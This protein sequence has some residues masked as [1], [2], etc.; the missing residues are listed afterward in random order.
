MTNEPAEPFR[1]RWLSPGDVNGF[2][3]LTID[4]L[5]LLAGMSAILVG[6]FHLPSGLVIGRM[7][8]GSALG[9]L[10]GDLAYTALAIRLA[11]CERRGDVCAMPLGI[12]TPSMFG[13]CFGVIGPAWQV[14][15]DADRTLAIAGA[16]LALM[17]LL[18]IAAAFFGEL[19]RRSLPRSAMLGALSAVAIALITF[20]SM[21]KIIAEPMG[22]MVALGV[23][24]STLIAGRR[25]PWRVPAMVAA[26]CLGTLAWALGHAVVG[27]VPAPTTA[28]GFG[29]HWL[30]PAPSLAWMDAIGLAMPYVPLALPFALVTL[31]G[32]IDN[33]ESAAA[34]G[35]R[36][37]T[38]DILLVEGVATFVA[39]LFGG[40]LQNT[41]YIGHPAYKR[42]GCRAGYTAATGLFIG[43]GACAGVVGLLVT[44][45]P[46]SVLVPI[47]VFVGLELSTQAF[48]ETD[49]KHLPAI[50]IAFIPAIAELVFVQWNG[51]LGGLGI[52]PEHLPAAQLAA[53]RALAVMANGFIVTSMLWSTLLIDIIDRRGPRIL[54][55]SGL[56]ACLT[57]FGVI[58]SPFP[59][60]R[61]FLP[62]A[63]LPPATFLLSAGY[64]LLGAVTW[65]IDRLDRGA[66]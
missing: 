13:L 44:W 15:G 3:A 8:P 29:V 34:A 64:V 1:Y 5:A 2:F 18:K 33:T 20:F 30:L 10:V 57:L 55:V 65:T 54:V 19:V 46:E 6:V 14:T 62:D 25:L 28:A 47:I 35:D 45:L 52:A 66:R 11:R 9:V 41:P 63:S 23:V 59:D 53:Y 39:A 58:H 4:N 56:A 12:D 61:L 60:G 49:G 38:R 37:A 36:Y 16:V 27:S 31:V 21:T 40:V 48:R 26:V 24:I 42:M 17:G 32:G 22:G 51:L 7:L 50:A 43:L